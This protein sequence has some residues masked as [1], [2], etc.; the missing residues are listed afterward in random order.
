MRFKGIHARSSYI[1]FMGVCMGSPS[2]ANTYKHTHTESTLHPVVLSTP[3]QLL[4]IQ[5]LCQR[6]GDC[7]G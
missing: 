6:R 3:G 1:R 4:L 2:V 7:L 5:M